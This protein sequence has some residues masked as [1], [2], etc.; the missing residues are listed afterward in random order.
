[1]QRPFVDQHSAEAAAYVVAALLLIGWEQL[2]RRYIA[3]EVMAGLPSYWPMIIMLC[4]AQLASYRWLRFKYAAVTEN[5]LL[6]FGLLPVTFL[7]IRKRSPWRCVAS[8]GSITVILGVSAFGRYTSTRFTRPVLLILFERGI[9][10]A[11]SLPAFHVRCSL[12]WRGAIA[13]FHSGVA[14]IYQAYY[15]KVFTCLLEAFTNAEQ[16]S[17]ST[18]EP[19]RVA[20]IFVVIDAMWSTLDGRT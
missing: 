2:M 18:E 15:G 4:V 6:F 19:F 1:M 9:L 20:Q 16:L 17:M 10:L 7:H 14:L 13:P 5:C 3:R 8:H 11:Y 12:A